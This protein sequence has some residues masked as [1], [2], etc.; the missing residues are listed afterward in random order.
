MTDPL[1]TIS[2]GTLRGLR[3]PDSLAFLGV[4]FAAAPIGEHRFAAPQPV[5]PWDGVRDATAYGPTPQRGDTGITL[6]PEPSVPGDA[7]LNV[8]VFTPDTDAAVPSPVLVWIHGGGYIS[9][10]PASPWY[11]GDTF[12]REGIVVVTL[13]YRLGFD[14]FGA[15]E[16][17]VS[18]RGVR[19][20]IAALEWVQQNIAAFG[21]D[22]A[23][24]T[25]GGQSAG[26]GAV[27]TLLGMPSAHHLFSAAW[28]ISGALGDVPLDEARAR[29]SRLAAAAGVSADRDGF[30]SVPEERLRAL[31]STIELA[32]HRGRLAPLREMIAERAW[33]PAIDDDLLRT[34]TPTSIASG[35]GADKPLL[36][37]STADEFTM[38]TDSSADKL[39]LV[40]AWLALAALGVDR[41]R[42][43]GYLRDNPG[44]RAKGTAAVLGRYVTDRVFGTLVP[45]VADARGSAAR[46]WAYRFTWPSPTI[47]WACH[48]LDVPF[49]FG[50]LEADGVARIAGTNPPASLAER[51]H[52]TAVAFIRDHTAAWTPWGEAPGTTQVFGLDSPVVADGYAGAA[53]LL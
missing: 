23:R 47:G 39:R 42:R 6:I 4:P 38:V 1:V 12:A 46:T 25:I 29:A 20:W 19:D 14:G 24:V 52:A 28:S 10:S 9:G 27:L 18:N 34:D 31:Q 13:S 7:T 21:G 8:N 33:G 5:T 26:G 53:A 32:P 17:A 37:G 43:R 22:P 50:R 30:A 51:M 44:P 41:R 16:G 49:W 11:D 40:P 2:T 15:I 35:V 45:R 48:C 3:R 36:L